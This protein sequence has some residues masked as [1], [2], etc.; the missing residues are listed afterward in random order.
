MAL[1]PG[2]LVEVGAQEGPEEVGDGLGVLLAPAMLGGTAAV[3][4]TRLQ[5]PVALLT[6]SNEALEAGT[7]R[8]C[9]DFEENTLMFIEFICLIC[10]L[11]NVL[12]MGL[13]L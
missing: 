6:A 11:L 1:I 9:F 2:G 5:K 4:A 3:L 7:T 10:M 12:H 8:K 13:G